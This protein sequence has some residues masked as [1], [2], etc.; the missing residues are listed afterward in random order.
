MKKLLLAS[1]AALTLPLSL[2]SAQTI[3]GDLSELQDPG[4]T[5]TATG[6]STE[7]NALYIG[8]DVTNLYLGVASVFDAAS[9][10]TEG[11]CIFIDSPNETFGSNVVSGVAGAGGGLN[12]VTL[13]TGFDP[14]F[15][16]L[17]Q[18]GDGGNRQNYFLNV[19][20]MSASA[21]DFWGTIDVSVPSFSTGGG[22]PAGAVVA[23]NNGGGVAQ[24]VE[25]QIPLSYINANN[26][27]TI[28]VFVASIDGSNGYIDSMTLPTSN[29]TAAIGGG[30]P[31]I[32]ANFATNTVGE[33]A[34]G[35]ASISGSQL[36]A[37]TLDGN[38][39]VELDHF[40]VD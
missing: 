24:G 15:C 1:M 23:L 13:E 34:G 7:L 30:Q 40:I 14:D 10:G 25:L 3:D 39:P 26:G 5:E 21:D 38:V 9:G 18:N 35:G 16:F 6:F 28:N 32:R 8:N 29:S 17:F 36:F 2:V 31:N 37:H 19:Y 20:D 27:D 11:I 4:I 22:L 33:F 12:G